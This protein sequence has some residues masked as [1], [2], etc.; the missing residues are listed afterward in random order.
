[1][2]LDPR[3]A[4]NLLSVLQPSLQNAIAIVE[5]GR[6]LEEIVRASQTTPPIVQ[7][8]PNHGEDPRQG[9][10][11]GEPGQAQRLADQRPGGG[12]REVVPTEA[13]RRPEQVRPANSHA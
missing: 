7:G 1:M 4:Q 8:E 9:R 11:Q 2:E 5:A 10:P 13:L 6:A 12:P 3:I